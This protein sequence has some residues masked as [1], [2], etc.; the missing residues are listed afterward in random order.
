MYHRIVFLAPVLVVALGTTAAADTKSYAALKAKLPGA[1]AVVVGI[2]FK[3]ARTASS[4]PKFVEAAFAQSADVKQA[5]DLIKQACG[6]DVI[7]A[8]SDATIAAQLDDKIV[9]AL[10]LDGVDEAKVVGCANKIIQK[11]DPK[12][13]LTA[14]PGKITEYTMTGESQKLYAAWLA[15]D[16]VAFSGDFERRDMLDAVIAGKPAAGDLAAMLAKTNAGAFVFAA[17]ALNNKDGVNGCF[18]TLQLANGKLALAAKVVAVDAKTGGALL[19]DGKKE[20]SAMQ[21][22]TKEP[23]VAK[24]LKA[25][26]LTGVGA[27]IAVEMALPEADLPTLVP[28]FD[29]LF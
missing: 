11:S 2:D 8:I 29:K 17:A 23:A 13:K 27:E 26:K 16:V 20:L 10:G 7:S 18:G 15:K 28:A 22:R 21:N 1:T 12:A 3:I 19:G 24:V 25:I 4:F 14:K 6:I 9:I 5:V